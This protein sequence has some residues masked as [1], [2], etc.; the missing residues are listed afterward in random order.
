MNPN[1]NICCSDPQFVHG[2]CISCG[3]SD[4][5]EG[6]VFYGRMPTQ[7][8]R[9]FV[10]WFRDLEFEEKGEVMSNCVSIQTPYADVLVY[11]GDVLPHGQKSLN[12]FGE[13]VA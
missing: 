11:I 2:V 12:D 10:N 8:D 6:P 3:N 7:T 13:V 1:D 5:A 4:N 9:R